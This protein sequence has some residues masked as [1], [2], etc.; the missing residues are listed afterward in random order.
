MLF[1]LIDFFISLHNFI[2]SIEHIYILITL[3]LRSLGNTDKL[4]QFT[5]HRGCAKLFFSVQLLYES[6][7]NNDDTWKRCHR[8]WEFIDSWR[9]MQNKIAF[10]E[11]PSYSM[12]SLRE[13]VIQCE[14]W[15]SI[16][17]DGWTLAAIFLYWKVLFQNSIL[18][19]KADT[20]QAI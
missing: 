8:G 20:C 18:D 11:A 6:M 16:S 10:F 13:P 14:K 17:L 15:T 7:D 12:L 4:T 19:H 2:H 1:N 9:E 3:S 5:Q